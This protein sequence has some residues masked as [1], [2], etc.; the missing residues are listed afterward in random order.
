MHFIQ[1]KK[2]TIYCDQTISVAYMQGEIY[3]DTNVDD[4]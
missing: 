2:I 4:Y 3:D 1:I